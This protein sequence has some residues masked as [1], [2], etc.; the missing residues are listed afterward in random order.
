VPNAEVQVRRSTK[1]SQRAWEIRCEAYRRGIEAGPEIGRVVSRELKAVDDVD[2]AV[3][4]EASLISAG[5]S[6]D[7]QMRRRQWMARWERK[8]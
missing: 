6:G 3:E 7:E 8:S 4:R 2:V 1:W 5:E